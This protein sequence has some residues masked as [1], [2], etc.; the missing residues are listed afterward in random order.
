M[1]SGKREYGMDGLKDY[2]YNRKYKKIIR[3]KGL[4]YDEIMNIHETIKDIET[5]I[6]NI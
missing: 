5:R 1:L 3:R 2:F 4:N 6:K